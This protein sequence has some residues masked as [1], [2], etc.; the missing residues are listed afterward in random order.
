MILLTGGTGL[1]G[2][3]LLFELASKGRKIRA[4]RRAG[5]Y[6]ELVKRLFAWYDPDHGIDLYDQVE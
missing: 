3:H 6:T 2:S 4:I 1:V 5:S